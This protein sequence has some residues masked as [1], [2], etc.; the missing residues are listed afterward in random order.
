MGFFLILRQVLYDR[1][2]YAPYKQAY[3]SEWESHKDLKGWLCRSKSATGTAFCK[4][5]NSNLEPKF[6]DLVKHKATAKHEKNTKVVS[7]HR[8]LES[9]SSVSMDLHVS[10]SELLWA[11]FTAEHNLSFALS[12]HATRV[13]TKMFPDSQIAKKFS[14]SFFF[15]FL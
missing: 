1:H 4:F 12:D 5:C 8:P 2:R 7:Q 15:F 9:Y 13:F 10:T 3:R 14:S 6:C 11:H